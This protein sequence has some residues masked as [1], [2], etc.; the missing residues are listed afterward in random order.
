MGKADDLLKDMI[1]FHGKRVAK[2]VVGNLPAHVKQARRD[3]RSIEKTLA[4]LTRKVDQ[5]LEKARAE[6]PV[7][8]ASEEVLEKARFTKRTLPA[9]RKRFGLIQQELAKLL[10]VGALTVSSWERGKARPRSKSLARIIALRSM[11]QEQVDEALGRQAAPSGV[12][13]RQIKGIREKL[14]LSQGELAGLIG[15][16]AA[17]V[18]S[19]E[20]GRSAPGPR[21]RKA[22]AGIA[23]LNRLE[24][25][26][27]LGRSVPPR[28]PAESSAL[29]PEEIRKI[30][31]GAGLSQQG[32][33]E[34]LGV[35]SNSVSNWETGSTSPRKASI[36]KLLAMRK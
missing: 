24:V 33:A 2:D 15:V 34:A 9:L 31:Q 19:W 16:S 21:N 7:P 3:I 17:A 12:D 26:E 30:R 6:S 13:P 25:D 23:G 36:E 35:S 28:T 5:L 1:R 18:G 11:S 22:L 29:S 10:R 20:R 32:L 14:G 8:P 27:R 4:G